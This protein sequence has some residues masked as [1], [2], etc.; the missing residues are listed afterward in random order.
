[1]KERKCAFG[2]YI[3]S[4]LCGFMSV[5]SFL[6]LCKA[7]KKNKAI[8][9]ENAINYDFRRIGDDIRNAMKKIRG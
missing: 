7:T 5:F 1:M 2:S 8:L 6:F 9:A 3:L 4:F